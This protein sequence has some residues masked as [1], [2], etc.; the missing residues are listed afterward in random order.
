M[1]AARFADG[2]EPAYAG[3]GFLPGI[4]RAWFADAVRRRDTAGIRGTLHRT[5]V[6]PGEV[7]GDFGRVPVG[8]GQA[9]AL[10]ASLP[11]RIRAG[12]EALRVMRCLGPDVP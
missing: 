10:P 4:D 2:T 6:H 8:R 11:I 1:R 5:R 3:I 7:E 9:F 12:R